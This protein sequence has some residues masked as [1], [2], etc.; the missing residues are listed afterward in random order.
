MLIYNQDARILFPRYGIAIPSLDSRKTNTLQALMEDS[1]LGHRSREWLIK[2]FPRVID[3][4][5][6]ARAHSPAYLERLFG[7]EQDRT[8]IEAYE[9]IDEK[10]KLQPLRSGRRGSLWG[11]RQRCDAYYLGRAMPLSQRL[12]IPDSV[13][14][15]AVECTTPIPISATASAC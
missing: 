11:D 14:F 5:D 12:W 13:T 8:L 6:L 2:D 9:L 7:S 4:D 10:G 1:G 3:R 15:W